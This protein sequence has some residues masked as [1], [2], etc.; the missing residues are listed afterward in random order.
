VR[1]DVHRLIGH[2]H[3]QG[4]GVGIAEYGDGAIAE[5]WAVR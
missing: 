4:I 1:A 5:A 2:L 3:V